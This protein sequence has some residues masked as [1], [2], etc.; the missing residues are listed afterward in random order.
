MAKKRRRSFQ[1]KK[2]IEMI[3]AFLRDAKGW[4]AFYGDMRKRSELMSILGESERLLG[5]TIY[6]SKVIIIDVRCKQMTT[7]VHECLHCIFDDLPEAKILELEKSV[8]K[9]LTG[10]DASTIHVLFAKR[11]RSGQEMIKRISA[12]M[13]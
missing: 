3:I 7:I 6:R 11:L 4:K 10:D 12:K 13:L 9:A 1:P 2:L 8:M 5:Y